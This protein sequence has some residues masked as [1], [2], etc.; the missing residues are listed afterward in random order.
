MGSQNTSGID[1]NLAYSF[2]GLGLDWKI[3][4]D[5]T[6]LLEFEQDGVSYEAP[7]MV[8]SVVMPRYVTTSVSKPV[9]AIGA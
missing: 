8:T 5:L 9:K 7:V 4:N 1:F 2:E 3:N 6:Y